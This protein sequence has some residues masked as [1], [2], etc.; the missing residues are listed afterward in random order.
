MSDFGPAAPLVFGLELSSPF[1]FKCQACGACCHNKAIA[2][3][4][5]EVE[6]LAANRGLPAGE[7]RRLFT[8]E[9]GATLLNRPDGSCVF[10]TEGRC[11]VHPDRPLVC[12]MFP[13]G[14]LRNDRGSERYGV[15]PLHP[16]CLGIVDGEATV[17]RYFEEQGAVALLVSCR[18]V[19]DRGACG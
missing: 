2:V 5:H 1:S 3:G 10:L 9:D 4:P 7:F 11:A 12:R 6:R 14:L 15:M 18:R 13:I 16:D 8:E 19:P 17:E